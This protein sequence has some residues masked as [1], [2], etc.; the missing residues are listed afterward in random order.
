M[1]KLNSIEDLR[2]FATAQGLRITV[3]IL[4]E[5]APSF[6]QDDLDAI[7]SSLELDEEDAVAWEGG[8]MTTDKAA[9]HF[10]LYEVH[11]LR[12][13]AKARTIYARGGGVGRPWMV[14][15]KSILM[16]INGIDDPR[17]K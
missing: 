16:H 15:P 12:R 11:D 3:E 7:R 1:G 10:N 6:N 4:P 17:L 5:T 9:K 2:R 13:M 14:C 8:F